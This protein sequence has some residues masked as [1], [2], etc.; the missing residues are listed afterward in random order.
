[1]N[2]GEISLNLSASVQTI[3][4]AGKKKIHTNFER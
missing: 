4:A 3:D 1:M 2:K